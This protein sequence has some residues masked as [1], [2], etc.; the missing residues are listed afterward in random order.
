MKKIAYIFSVTALI[1]TS[2]C[3]Q[4]DTLAGD[5]TEETVCVT[6]TAQADCTIAEYNSDT[7]RKHTTTRATIDTDDKPVRFFAQA[8]DENGNRTEPVAGTDLDGDEKYSFSLNLYPHKEYDLLFWA[9]NTD[10]AVPANLEEVTYKPGSVAFAAKASGKPVSI[11]KNITL[12]H[13]VTKVT[14]MTTNDITGEA[15]LRI[16]IPTGLKYNVKTGTA[17]S[18]SNSTASFTKSVNNGE[19][20][21]T[22]SEILSGYVLSQKENRTVIIT[23]ETNNKQIVVGGLIFSPDMHMILKGNLSAANPD[24]KPIQ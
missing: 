16:D 20:L 10:D 11:D 17:D 22:G 15:T 6:F 1:I 12:K 5:P 8:V 4:D 14:L 18:G 2:A 21:T 24:W 13:V 3:S 19:N 23:D 9:D 7:K